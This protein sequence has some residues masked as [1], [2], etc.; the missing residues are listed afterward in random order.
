LLDEQFLHTVGDRTPRDIVAHL[1]GWNYHAIEASDF[2]RRGEMPPS[3]ID[4]GPDFSR[5]NG[6]SI[7]RFASQDKGA[8]LGQLR[9]SGVAYDAMLRDLPAAEWEDNHGVVLGKWAVTNDA[10]VEIM[11]GEFDHHRQ[12]IETWPAP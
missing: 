5:V 10:F 7:A 2:V 3:L 6:E 4:P 9:E 11:I 1:I 12:E 8:L